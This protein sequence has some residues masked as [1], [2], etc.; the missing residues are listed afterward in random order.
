MHDVRLWSILRPGCH[1]EVSPDRGEH[2][3]LF[4]DLG[5][6]LALEAHEFVSVHQ[7]VVRLVK[8]GELLIEYA[9]PL[10][11]RV[12]IFE[13]LRER[14]VLLLLLES[15]SEFGRLRLNHLPVTLTGGVRTA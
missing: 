5:L 3:V 13:H 2:A 14:L 1:L 7:V 15:L 12:V 4:E 9:K 11:H 10:R 6:G 8:V